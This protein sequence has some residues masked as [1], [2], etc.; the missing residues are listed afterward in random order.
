MASSGIFLNGATL[1]SYTLRWNG[2]SLPSNPNVIQE[3]HWSNY[4]MAQTINIGTGKIELTIGHPLDM[5]TQT[6][7]NMQLALKANDA[8]MTTAFAG[9]TVLLS[10]KAE[11]SQVL[12]NVPA[13]VVFTDTVYSHPSSHPISMIMGLQTELN[14]ISDLKLAYQD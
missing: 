5:A 3:L 2:S 9:Y 7:T 12:T 14:K 10:Q 6:W 4:T 8:D 1:S 11:T 13:N